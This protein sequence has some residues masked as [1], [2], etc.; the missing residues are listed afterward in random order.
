MNNFLIF[1]N[2]QLYDID[3]SEESNYAQEKGRNYALLSVSNCLF[4]CVK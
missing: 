4:F 3:K 2:A 1:L